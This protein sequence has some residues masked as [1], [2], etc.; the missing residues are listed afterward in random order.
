MSNQI[1]QLDRRLFYFVNHDLGNPFFDWL[2]PLLRNP[3]V[4]I[5]LYVFIFIF[6]LYRYKKAGA[7]IIVLLALTFA[8]ADYGSA[9][10][11]KNRVKRLRPCHE[12]ALAGTIIVRIPCGSGYSFPSAHA[13]NHFAIACFFSLV[14]Y[15]RWKYIWWVAIAWAFFISFAQVY[16][17]VH[18]PFDVTFGALYG[19]LVGYVVYL[20]FKKLQPQF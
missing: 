20:L 10:L 11:I 12:P 18:Y 9:G 3:N 19:L 13:S 1:L 2:M 7:Y 15:S 16:V 14:F 8:I 4:W 6:C 17:G 5:P